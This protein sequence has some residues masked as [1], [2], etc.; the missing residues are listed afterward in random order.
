M[1]LK[2]FIYTLGLRPKPR[3]FGYRRQLIELPADG[4]TAYARWLHPKAQD[5]RI[6]PEEMLELRR[7]LKPGDFAIDIGAHSGDSTLPIALACGAEGSVLALEPNSYAFDILKI[8]AKLNPH[9]TNIIPLCCAVTE[10]EGT[11]EFRYGD[12]GFIN[13]GDFSGRS[14]WEH[15]SAFTLEVRGRPLQ[16]IL[17]EMPADRLA[18][19]RYIK[20]DTE[21]HDARI[22]HSIRDIL[23]RYRPYIKAEVYGRLSSEE[24][25]GLHGLL[26]G[27][28][29]SVFKVEDG[30]L[31]TERRLGASDM[32][33]WTHFDIFAIP[34]GSRP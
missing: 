24:R 16:N 25:T 8:N 15:G 18:R 1:K 27:L 6:A 20:T 31:F 28:G 19:L 22:L 14:V 23:E 12:P 11:F 17:N 2:E 5:L 32:M 9:K 26:S 29:Y 21:G 3:T 33:R 30:M 34:D 10:Q 7:F 13:G 4:A